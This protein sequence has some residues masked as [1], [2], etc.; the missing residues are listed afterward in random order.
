M[1]GVKKVDHIIE[2]QEN[3]KQTK[4]KMDTENIKD[5]KHLKN[6]EDTGEW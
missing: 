5:I 2:K 3:K 4:N 1:K 6:V